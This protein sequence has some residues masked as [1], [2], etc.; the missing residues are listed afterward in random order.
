MSGGHNGAVATAFDAAAIMIVQHYVA[1]VCVAL[2]PFE[3]AWGGHWRVCRSVGGAGTCL[4]D[5]RIGVRPGMGQVHCVCGDL[6]SF[7]VRDQMSRE[8]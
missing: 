7:V 2:A 6:C 8:I 3:R 4:Y 5:E 1:C